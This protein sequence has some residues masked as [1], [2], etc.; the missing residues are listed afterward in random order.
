[1]RG[2]TKTQQQEHQH[3]RHGM[4]GLDQVQKINTKLLLFYFF[5]NQTYHNT[6]SSTEYTRFIGIFVRL[7][8]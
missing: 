2:E 8:K 3:C 5:Q 4:V 6:T 1:M 7:V